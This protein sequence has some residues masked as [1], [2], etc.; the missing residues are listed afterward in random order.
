MIFNEYSLGI[1]PKKKEGKKKEVSISKN[2]N[3]RESKHYIFR[4]AHHL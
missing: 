1:I 4:N 2:E 3:T